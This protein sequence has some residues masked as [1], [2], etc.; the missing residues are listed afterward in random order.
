[1]VSKKIF[2]NPNNTFTES[3]SKF[4]LAFT[5]CMKKGEFFD[6]VPE[7]YKTITGTGLNEK[8]G[9]TYIEYLGKTIPFNIAI[10][11]DAKW[12]EIE[13][14]ICLVYDY[15][16]FEDK[17]SLL[18]KKINEYL[19]RFDIKFLFLKGQFITADFVTN[20]PT[21][22]EVLEWIDLYPDAAKAYRAALKKLS[23]KEDTRNAIDDM[24]L[25]LESLVRDI[26]GTT[27]TLENQIQPIGSALKNKGVLPQAVTLVTTMLNH[28]AKYQNDN[29]K[30]HDTVDVNDSELIVNMTA[31][32]MKYIRDRLG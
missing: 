21:V 15:V 17:R 5:N 7:E 28:Y 3:V 19:G 31:I 11:G 16:V 4:W 29:V 22:T 1:M 9:S 13:E 20:Q 2:L 24:R 30:H 8:W 27:K 12:D 6:Y 32:I 25:A 26:M 23:N 10:L 14:F 18:E